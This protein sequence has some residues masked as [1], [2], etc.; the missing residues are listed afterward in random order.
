M[1]GSPESRAVVVTGVS[2]GIGLGIAR[3]LVRHGV[4]VFGSVRRSDDGERVRAE[5]GARFTP[6]VF[7]VANPASIQV[8]VPIVTAHLGG[9]TLWGLVNNAGIAIGGPLIYQPL[10]EVRRVIEVNTIGALATTQAFVPLLGTDRSRAGRPGRIVNISSV[11]GRLSAPFLGAYAASKRGLEGMSEALRRELMMFG[12]DVIVINPGA[13]ATPIWDKAEVQSGERYEKTEYA[14]LLQ[15][16]LRRALS[17]GR[18]G[19]P[20]ESI[21]GVVWEVLTTRRPRASYPVMRNRLTAWTIPLALPTRLLDRLIA[22]RLG[23]G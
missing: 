17:T 2:T 19:L 15:R 7:D 10:D 22:R 20:V 1:S 14:P 8:S 3:V 13:I 5:L 16:F 9:R 23:I 21:G 11:A 4:H 6:L 18:S 12:I